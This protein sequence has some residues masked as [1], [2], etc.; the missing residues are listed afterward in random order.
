MSEVF[1]SQ[2]AL[3]ADAMPVEASGEG[4]ARSSR[5]VSRPEPGQSA[6]R[7]LQPPPPPNEREASRTTI[8]NSLKKRKALKGRL[9]R[10]KLELARRAWETSIHRLGPERRQASGRR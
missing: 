1:V 3:S 8:G 2:V 9:C 6:L 7:G 4:G 10:G 5:G